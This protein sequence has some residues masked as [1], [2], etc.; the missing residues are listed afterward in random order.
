MPRD[1]PRAAPATRIVV[2][3]ATG[4]TGRL[5]ARAL[6]DRGARP[7]LVA[8]RREA[9]EILARELGGLRVAVADARRPATLREVLKPG[10]VL[11]TT[12]GPFVRFGDAAVEAAIAAGAQ[13]LDSAGE[14][15]FVRRVFERHGP[16]AAR[17][18]TALVPSFAFDYVPGNVAAALA[19]Q[20]LGEAARRVDVGYF[21]PGDRRWASA[22]SRASYLGAA[23][24]P[25]FAW[26][27]GSLRTERA[28]ART[29]VFPVD[30]GTRRAV[31]AGG[32]EHFALPRLHP[33]LSDVD[34]YLG[35]LPGPPRALQALSLAGAALL[36]VPGVRR[37]V[38]ATTQVAGRASGGGPG[39]HAR[40]KTRTEVVA[41]AYDARGREGAAARLVGGNG[42]D[43]TA[44]LLAWGAIEAARGALRG[45]G[46]LGPVEAF[47]LDALVAACE[48]AGMTPAARA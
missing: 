32:S 42:Y 21:M 33:H 47:G 17:A 38:R 45:V 29:R 40:T 5:V 35:Y 31:S 20:E 26:R 6:V 43:L 13:Y 28:A 41:I 11:V 3:G 36:R 4:Y 18:G 15:P 30:G 48:D 16:L 27:A 12:V 34:T 19:I 24:E 14:P 25:S 44:R 22:G 9:L 46:A 8:R 1:E 2:F 23:L 37:T 10:D 7:L 39:E